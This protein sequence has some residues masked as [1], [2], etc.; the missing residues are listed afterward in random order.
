MGMKLGLSLYS[1]NEGSERMFKEL[2]AEENICT[3]GGS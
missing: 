3:T 1:R 2:S